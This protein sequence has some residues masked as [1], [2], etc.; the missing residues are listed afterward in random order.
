MK[1]NTLDFDAQINDFKLL[2]P[3]LS[4][5]IRQ[6]SV[7]YYDLWNGSMFKFD[8]TRTLLIDFNKL[9]KT[10]NRSIKNTAYAGGFM[11]YYIRSTKTIIV[12]HRRDEFGKVMAIYERLT[13]RNMSK[14]KNY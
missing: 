13:G 12:Y 5:P 3:D 11:F 2:R 8:S 1:N 4:K 10:E 9:K 7:R 6:F 14:F